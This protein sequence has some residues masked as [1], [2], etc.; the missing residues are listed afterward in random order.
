MTFITS[1][2]NHKD[3]FPKKADVVIAGG[4]IIG[5]SIAWF[6]SKKNISV[7]LC[8]KG[9]IAGE[10]SSRNW[11]FCR[12]QGRDL[13]ELPLMQES[14]RIWADL[15]KNIGANVGFRKVGSL[16][17]ARDEEKMS[18][19][20]KW[21]KDVSDFNLDTQ[22]MSA[23]DVNTILHGTPHTWVGGML[24]PSDGRAE[25]LLATS[26]IA[27]AARTEGTK[28]LTNCA[29]RGID[30]KGGRISHAITEKGEIETKIV[31]LA[32]GVWSTLFLRR[33]GLRFP[34]LLVHSSVFRTTPAPLISECNVWDENFAF[35]RRL[36]NGYTI[37]NG[38]FTLVELVPDNFRL[39]RKFFPIFK[40]ESRRLAFR[41]RLGKAFI[42]S[43]KMPKDWP[44][45]RKSPLET[46]RV[47][48]PKPYMP[49]LFKTVNAL[50]KDIPILNKVRI[51][52]CWAGYIDVTPDA[53]PVISFINSPPGL[54]LASG[55]SGHGFGIGLGA[56]KLASELILNEAPSVDP[57]PFRWA[58]TFGLK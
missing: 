19:M 32:G 10:Q 24:T 31:V 45:D 47:L 48:N 51:A 13:K 34:Q 33:F 53:L 27:N 37:A 14:L 8:E 44:L 40:L 20:E 57:T 7:V 39:F 50:R 54:F 21:L 5:A 29:V 58:R 23:N 11:G 38:S 18:S 30:T 1:S 52:G 42:K 35:R 25:P 3:S 49:I 12:Q 17:L 4:G 41:M 16:Y 36:D 46:Y 2:K 9:K 6:L 28:I 15:E 26:E 56:G 22:L 55:F 43:F